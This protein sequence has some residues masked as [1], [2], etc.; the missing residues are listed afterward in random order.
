M[1]EVA[2]E[3][4]R[5]RFVPGQP[6]MWAFVLF[7]TLVFTAYFGFYLF[8]RARDPEL[9]L[10]SQAHLDLRIGVFNTLVLLL[11]S[12][13][14]ARCVQSARAGAYPAA[15][16]DAFITA[17]FA[18]VFLLGKVFEWARL[19]GTG[20]GLGSNDFFTYYFFL[21]G[22]HFVHLLIGFVALGVI[23]YQLRGKARKAHETRE[24]QQLVET[25]ATYWHTV[26]F[27]WVLIFALLY[28]VR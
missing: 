14:V 12:W 3:N 11:S 20:N 4:Q 2:D 7:E 24:S 13:S 22:I 6:D 27:L 8:S 1:T 21:T 16:R 23:V 19:V 25:C 18:V 15:L 17:G 10:Q 5:S 9:F 26:D 28:V